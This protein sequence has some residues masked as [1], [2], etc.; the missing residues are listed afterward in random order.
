MIVKLTI[1]IKQ[2]LLYWT[3]LFI[4]FSVGMLLVDLIGVPIGMFVM[5]GEIQLTPDF[6]T[7]ENSI[8]YAAISAFIVGIIIFIK[9]EFFDNYD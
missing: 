9:Q 1:A 6:E 8:E 3:Y 2:L 7:I 5:T 4:V